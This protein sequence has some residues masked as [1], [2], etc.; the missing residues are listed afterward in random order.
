MTNNPYYSRTD[1]SKL[2]VS[3]DVW[4]DILDEVTYY[5]A[6]EKGTE[7]PFSGVYNNEKRIGNY[8][9]KVCGQKLF[10]AVEKFDSGCGWPSFSSAAEKGAINYTP[11][12]SHNMNRI[13]VTCSRCDSHLGHVFED[14]PP[15]MYKRYCI[16][17]VSLEFEPE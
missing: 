11:D 3:N 2:N 8:Y 4:K 7:R 6:R 17:S 12:Y 10:N 16:N 15:P 14:G 9:C 13:E 5:V 1:K